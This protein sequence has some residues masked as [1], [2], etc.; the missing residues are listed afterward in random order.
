MLKNK[1]KTGVARIADLWGVI[2][3]ITGKVELVYEGEQ[4]GPYGV[5]LSLMSEAMKK[6]FLEN[7]PHIQALPFP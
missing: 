3:S 2:P 4:E 1:E 7:F 5:A 6:L